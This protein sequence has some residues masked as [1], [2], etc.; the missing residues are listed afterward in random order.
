MR[1]TRLWISGEAARGG[2]EAGLEN[3]EEEEAMIV[4]KRIR[5]VYFLGSVQELEALYIVFIVP[6]IR[7]RGPRILTVE[8]VSE[9]KLIQ[10]MD[11]ISQL[12]SARSSLLHRTLGG[13]RS[14]PK[15]VKKEF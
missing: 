6:P 7:T 4:I 10:Q 1:A 2:G 15:E 11:M 9:T 14:A 13:L 5:S 8:K 12:Q 3:I